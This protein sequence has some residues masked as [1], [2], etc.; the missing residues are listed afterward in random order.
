MEPAAQGGTAI[1]GEE[2]SGRL[3]LTLAHP[4]SRWSVTI[5]RFAA[6]VVQMLVVGV[7][8]AVALIAISGP[9]QFGEIGPANLAAASI[10]LSLL[11]I[12]FGALALAAGAATGRRGVAFGAVAIIAIGGFLGNNL[13]PMVE[14]LAWLRDV[15]PFHYYAGGLPLSNGFQVSD[16]LVLAVASVILVAVG[17]VVFDRRDVAV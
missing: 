15:S 3:D 13:G 5:Q 14:Q 16:A 7:A 4:V 1:A 2:E 11:G 6:I 10:H 9:A 8:L 12:V 17:G